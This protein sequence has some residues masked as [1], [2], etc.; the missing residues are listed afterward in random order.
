VANIVNIS[1]N[2][3]T[4]TATAS[5]KYSRSFANSVV[6]PTG[7][8]FTVGGESYAVPFSDETSDLYP[9]MWSPSTG[10]W[11]VMA[12]QAEPRNYHSVA[13]LLPDGTVFSGGGGLCGSCATNHP[14]GQIF[15]P[16]YLYNAERLAAHPPDDHLRPDLRGHGTDDLGDHRRPRLELRGRPL[17][18]GDPLR[19]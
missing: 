16:P 2:T 12:E 5:M 11:S 18:R 4:V 6:L 10:Q 9:E 3:P 14:D 7:Q 15:Y 17:R 1:G 19:R 13:V 8:V